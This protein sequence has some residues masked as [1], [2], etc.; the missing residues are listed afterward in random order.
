MVAPDWGVSKSPLLD[1]NHRSAR[2][3]PQIRRRQ[4]E[5]RVGRTRR[6]PNLVILVEVLVNEYAYRSGV[7]DRRHAADGKA[8]G[9]AY[10]IGVG[11]ADLV[12]ERGLQLL[13][14][15]PVDAARDHQHRLAGALG[16]EDHR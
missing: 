9:V 10:E 15:D 6:R 4:A 11:P 8:G 7:A 3:A 1:N 5:D 13:L 2:D 12:A 16:A 14:V